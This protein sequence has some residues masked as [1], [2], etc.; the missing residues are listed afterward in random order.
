VTALFLV[1]RLPAQFRAQRHQAG[2]IFRGRAITANPE[3]SAAFTGVGFSDTAYAQPGPLLLLERDEDAVHATWTDRTTEIGSEEP[4]V[5]ADVTER[6]RA[7]AEGFVRVPL[8][9]PSPNKEHTPSRQLRALVHRPCVV[10]AH[11]REVRLDRSATSNLWPEPPLV[12]GV[13]PCAVDR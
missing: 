1:R 4:R 12:Q 7:G 8:D 6:E 2:S 3:R 5:V 10:E 11:S 9:D 13:W